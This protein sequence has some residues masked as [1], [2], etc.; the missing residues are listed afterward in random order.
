M[1]EEPQSTSTARKR[2]IFLTVM[3]ALFVLLAISNFTKPLQH[4]NNPSRGGLVI[5]GHR[6]ETTGANAVF[7]PIFGLV[8]LAYVWGIWGMRRWVLPLAIVYAFY[9]PVNMV[10]FWYAH[11]GDPQRSLGFIIMYL[12]FAL[13]GSVGTALYLAYHREALN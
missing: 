10:L 4:M 9:V 3:A 13:T 7:G 2:G 6:L 1:D 12:A 5:L 8:L 11:G